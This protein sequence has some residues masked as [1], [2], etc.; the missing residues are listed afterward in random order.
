MHRFL[1]TLTV[2]A[3]AALS[4]PAMTDWMSASARSSW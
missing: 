2:I 4:P 3:L 1:T